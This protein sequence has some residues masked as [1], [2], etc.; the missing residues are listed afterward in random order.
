MSR[1]RNKP[2]KTTRSSGTYEQT[3]PR[4][5]KTGRTADLRRGNINPP[6]EKPNQ[7]WRKK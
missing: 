4:G 7:T 1:G 3:G 5:G 2:G 6:T